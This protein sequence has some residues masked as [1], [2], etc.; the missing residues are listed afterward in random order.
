MIHFEKTKGTSSDLDQNPLHP[1]HMYDFQVSAASTYSSPHHR[2]LSANHTFALHFRTPN[3]IK[4]KNAY[5]S[6]N[7]FVNYLVLS[8][9]L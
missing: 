4:Y 9:A 2:G 6:I 7:S 5:L 3:L 1:L 8:L